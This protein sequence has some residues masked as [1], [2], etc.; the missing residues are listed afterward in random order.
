LIRAASLAN[1][2]RLKKRDTALD[3]DSPEWLTLYLQDN[4][5]P[6]DAAFFR[7]QLDAGCLLELDGIDEVP[8]QI[9]RKAM[10]RLLERA[11][12]M[13]PKTHIVAAS[14]PPALGGETVIAGFVTIQIGPL[15][16]K[17]VDAFVANWCKAL[18]G[19]DAE[20]AKQH[21]AELLDAIRSRPEIARLATNPVM[22]TALASLH[23]N[24]TRLPD[25]RS[26][27]YQSV[28]DW[29]AQA[30]EEKR[31]DWREDTTARMSAVECL[32]KMQ[33]LAFTM[34]SDPRG[35]QTEITPHAAAR[36]LAP[37][38]RDLPEDE[39]I[40]AAERF[41]EEEETDSGILIRRG[42]TLRFWHLTFQEY[43]AAKVLAG[44]EAERRR[45]LFTEQKL[46]LAEWRPTV[47]LLSAVLC[48]Q[49]RDLADKFFHE[50]L[51]A[52]GTDAP[53]AKRARCVGLIGGALRDLKSWGYRLTDPRYQENLD[54][55]MAVFDA[56]EARQLDFD[57]RL[58]AADAIGLEGDPRLDLND[59]RY[60]VRVEGVPFRMG[61]QSAF[62]WDS[63]YDLEA[64]GDEA[65]VH[66]VA[67]AR[68]QMGRY[69]VTVFNYLQFMEGAGYS[70]ERFWT[71]GGYEQYLAPKHWQA[72]LRYPNRPVVN[73][74]WFEAAACC[75]WAGARL[76]TE[77]E[78]E[79]AARC[80]R[81]GGRYPW[82]D[83]APDE[84]RANFGRG[85]SGDLTP[86][87]L[88]PE[89]AA[90]RGIEDLAGN[91]SEWVDD[92]WRDHYE[93]EA[94]PG[95]SRMIRGGSWSSG[96]RN[97]R[98]SFRGSLQPGVRLYDVGF[99]CV[100]DLPA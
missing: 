99:R 67:V 40:A 5:Q 58:Y 92:W 16:S 13:F 56:R 82:G 7:A 54:R 22:L 61:A 27:L 31:K 1:F 79:C 88:Y 21:Q 8:G 19:G 28:L 68:F 24:R 37:R 86:V 23:W 48:K 47:L 71:A 11:A 94:K 85:G 41:L 76:P 66:R 84:Y 65:P 46:Y 59:P 75:A 36:A 53:L 95:G 90:T 44:R 77:A 52:L 72:Q 33:H 70:N 32:D 17:A 60:W 35:R 9:A 81:V 14:R 100:R 29:L 55:S 87:G 74:S 57:T 49:D 26:E 15:D 20:K 39:R 98:V 78:W 69:P 38:F 97:I 6:L 89:G 12:R 96:P 93:K 73:V 62:P 80:G 91:C 4:A 42:N 50:I 83:E 30:R 18:H 51:D 64:Y 10:A 63:N 45:L 34:H 43:L 2:I 25:Q 3:I